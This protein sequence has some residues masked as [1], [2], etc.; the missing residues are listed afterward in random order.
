MKPLYYVLLQMGR[1]MT[2][3]EGIAE[4][5]DDKEDDG[6]NKMK[7]AVKSVLNYS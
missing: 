4:I 6:N 5:T 7:R 3:N 1:F 2:K